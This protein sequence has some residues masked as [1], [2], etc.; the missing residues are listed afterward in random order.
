MQYFNISTCIEYTGRRLTR[1]E[2]GFNINLITDSLYGRVQVQN[3]TSNF[4]ICTNN[5]LCCNNHEI[6]TLETDEPFRLVYTEPLEFRLE[7]KLVKDKNP[8]NAI[9]NPILPLNHPAAEPLYIPFEIDCGDDNECQPELSLTARWLHESSSFICG[10]SRHVD[11]EV[12]VYNSGENAF[13]CRIE[14]IYNVPL[15]RLPEK[16]VQIS[17]NVLHCYVGNPLRPNATVCEICL[18]N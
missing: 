1:R 4:I 5:T 9:Y 8:S 10:S 7:Y 13:T 17:D 15:L 14:I 11:V 12:A 2:Y 3:N 18:F 6:A 16:C